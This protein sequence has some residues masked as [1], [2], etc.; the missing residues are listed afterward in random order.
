M[1]S[2]LLM[3]LTTAT[4][5]A[6]GL[7]TSPERQR[8]TL[9]GVHE[10]VLSFSAG[11]P[12]VLGLLNNS[13]ALEALLRNRIRESGIALVEGKVSSQSQAFQSAL[14]HFGILCNDLVKC[15]LIH[16]EIE[17]QQYVALARD[18]NTN[19]M[20]PTFEKTVYSS[21]RIK[22]PSEAETAA[23]ELISDAANV[24]IDAYYSAN[25]KKPSS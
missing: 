5:E 15:D 11:A 1:L 8:E 2:I 16:A 6:G 9:K 22:S 7:L 12:E 10:I 24:F 19:F 4:G 14:V 17:V 21:K 13:N 23:R 25:P 18:S 20:S 3:S